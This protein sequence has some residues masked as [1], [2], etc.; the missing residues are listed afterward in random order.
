MELQRK[1]KSS[2]L[3]YEITFRILA[4]DSVLRR[5]R[6]FNREAALLAE[7][8]VPDSAALLRSF[9]KPT[10]LPMTL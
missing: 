10:S 2:A 9:T 4:R 1:F 5:T 3:S 8:T 6:A 7:M